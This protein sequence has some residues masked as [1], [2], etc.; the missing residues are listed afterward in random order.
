M[1]SLWG[2]SEQPYRS[3]NITLQ[4][5][6][7][8]PA[9]TETAAAP[10]DTT[11]PEIVPDEK[12]TA[13]DAAET[14]D[15]T[16]ADTG[17]SWWSYTSAYTAKLKEQAQNI[18]YT[19]ITSKIGEK[20]NKESMESA[21]SN[22]GSYFN[23]MYSSVKTSV[24]SIQKE[25]PAIPM[26]SEFE[27]EQKKFAL[28][29]ERRRGAAVPP[30][31][32]YNE[33]EK[34]KK[35]ILTLSADERN[36][37]RDPP[38]GVEFL[39]DMDTH[40]PVALAMLDHDTRLNDMR[41]RLVP[42]KGFESPDLSDPTTTA[43]V[44]L[45]KNGIGFTFSKSE[46]RKF[47]F[48]K[49]CLRPQTSLCPRSPR[50]G[51]VSQRCHCWACLIRHDMFSLWGSSEQPY[52]ST[53]IT[54]QS[55]DAAETSDATAADTGSSWW[56]YTS[57]YTA[58]LKEQAQNIDYTKITSKIGEKVNKES[59]ESARSNLGSYFNNMYSSVKTSVESIQKEGPAIPMLS[60]FE[61]EQKKFALMQERR[62]GAAVPPWVGYNEEEK[63]KKQILTL[64]ADERNVMRDPPAGVEFLF[65]MDT[66]MPVALAMLD[67]DT[68]LNDM[69][70]RLVPKV[71][72]EESFWRNYFYRVS[73]IKQSAQL[74][75]LD[76]LQLKIN[77]DL[78]V[79]KFKHLTIK[80]KQRFSSTEIQAVLTAVEHI[81]H[82]KAAES[83]V[84]SGSGGTDEQRM[85]HP[86]L[87]PEL[88][89]SPQEEEFI[90]D[91][92]YED[93]EEDA[94]L[95]E[96]ELKQMGLGGGSSGKQEAEEWEAELEKEL[97]DFEM[98]E[99][100]DGKLD[101]DNFEAEL[102]EMLQSS[103]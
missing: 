54:L 71:I 4:S 103:D 52:R 14:S 35:Q 47:Y 29:Q 27:E 1:F 39:F 26:L 90:S 15:A 22:L 72:K 81:T 82:S 21:R 60:E 62:R 102:E 77:N 66:H 70:F 45:F 5:E 55:E 51:G 44:Q 93:A 96:E 24:E 87:E 74:A 85:K 20:V 65:D 18:D 84:T 28:M 86:S 42:K 32:G 100:A 2:S 68:R 25:G 57:A 91:H 46:H 9:A 101:S 37:M 64:S 53:N 83:P 8:E 17:S 23:N 59:M 11:T 92:N 49:L 58:K 69:R 63:I 98:V 78:A 41:F 7:M 73:L 95:N 13:A 97:Q 3:T 43:A 88:S 79:L 89:M 30:W 48:E 76:I 61:E 36:V 40:M 12:P 75:T 6:G 33:E 31:V 80:D 56:S 94:V 38:A 99:G 10:S 34:I 50:A 67:H 16:A 19:K